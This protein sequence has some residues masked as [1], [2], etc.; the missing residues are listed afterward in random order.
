MVKW[1]PDWFDTTLQDADHNWLV[2]P[3]GDTAAV[4]DKR[5]AT[6]QITSENT[7]Y[8]AIEPVIDHTGKIMADPG[9]KDGDVQMAEARASGGSGP[10]SV[11][12][13]TPISNYPSLTYGLQE[14]HTTIL[15]WTG[16][17]T[18]VK[19]PSS[20]NWIPQQLKI[21]MNTPYD[22]LDVAIR[23]DPGDGT[24]FGNE[25]F[26]AVPSTTG[27]AQATGARYPERFT[28]NNTEATERPAWRN[29]WASIYDFYTVLGCEYQ[30]T[31]KNPHTTAGFNMLCGVQY[32]TY[33]DTA[34]STGNVMPLTR[35]SEVMAFKNIKWYPIWCNNSNDVERSNI[36]VISGSY[37]PGQA[38][39]NIVNDGDV[40]TWTATGTTLPTLKE[41]L[42]LNFWQHPLNEMSTESMSALNIQVDLKYIVQ[43][44][45]LK[46]QA[47]YP[48]TVTADQDISLVLNETNTNANGLQRWA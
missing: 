26:Y 25:G 42:T 18:A 44:K 2:G 15:P 6:E 16:W 4:G 7:K 48:N 33:S 20:N 1:H 40:K 47:R 24:S 41:I 13:E 22:M 21:R 34:T 8:Q 36:T 45:D 46:Q 30:I 35:L 10:S 5:P 3:G 11:S 9:S 38:K 17:L 29:F 23:A 14:T 37:K 28:T 19:G 32:D 31:I 27:A 39:R 43:F 12:K